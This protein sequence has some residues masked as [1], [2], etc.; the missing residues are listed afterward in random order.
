MQSSFRSSDQWHPVWQQK[1]VQCSEIWQREQW[2]LWEAHP[3][4]L[5]RDAVLLAR[6]LHYSLLIHIQHHL[7]LLLPQLHHHPTHTLHLLLHMVQAHRL[8][9]PMATHPLMVHQPLTV[10]HPTDTEVST[11]K[12][13]RRMISKNFANAIMIVFTDQL[14]PQNAKITILFTA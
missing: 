8:L 2:E 10:I 5:L 4:L 14:M 3:L 7:P 1:Q 12:Q 9:L 6:M 13:T 11:L